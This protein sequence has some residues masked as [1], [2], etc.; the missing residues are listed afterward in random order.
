MIARFVLVLAA[1]MM[2]MACSSEA[3]PLAPFA[4]FER[5]PTPLVGELAL[6]AVEADGSETDFT[7]QADE[8]DI[9][10]VYFGYTSCP[11]VCPTTLSDV[12]RAADR[13]GDDAERVDLA[14]ITIDPLVDTPDIVAG[15]VSSFLP[16]AVALRTLD[17]DRLRAVADVFGADYGYTDQDGEQQVYHTGSLY[18]IDSSGQLILTWSFGTPID[19]LESDLGRLLK[20]AV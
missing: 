4:G 15:Y 20:E 8:G 7:F 1:T 11:D 18:A 19:D 9:L 14:M 2:T 12:R 17:D 3:K 5:T 10:L 6:P 16:R 13:L